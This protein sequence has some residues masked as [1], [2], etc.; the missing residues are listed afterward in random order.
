MQ[1]LE[2]SLE[3]VSSSFHTRQNSKR[4]LI[5]QLNR[6]WWVD[7]HLV[8]FDS[9]GEVIVAEPSPKGY[10]EKAK[11]RV[12]DKGGFTFPSFADGGIFV[13]NLESIARVNVQ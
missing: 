1:A 13:R 11:V 6:P 8:I 7:D 2:L 5:A 4:Y 9:Q 12:S 10:N 3:G